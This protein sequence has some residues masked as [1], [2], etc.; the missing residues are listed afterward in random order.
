MAAMKPGKGINPNASQPQA[1]IVSP[2]KGKG[3]VGPGQVKPNKH[4]K[5]R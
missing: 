5:G 1:S 4:P 2:K 3:S